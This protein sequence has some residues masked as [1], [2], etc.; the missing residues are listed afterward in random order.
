MNCLLCVFWVV[1]PLTMATEGVESDPAAAEARAAQLEQAIRNFWSHRKSIRGDIITTARL[2]DSDIV[3]VGGGG[4]E[5]LKVDDLVLRR[6][7]QIVRDV[8]KTGEQEFKDVPEQRQVEFEDGKDYWVY[9][10]GSDA[11]GKRV[12]AGKRD[13]RRI[14]AELRSAFDLRNVSERRT[15]FGRTYDLEWAPQKPGAGCDGGLITSF[16]SDGILVH[17][18]CRNAAGESIRTLLVRNLQYDIPFDRSRF[19]FTPPE[20]VAVKELKEGE[21]LPITAKKTETPPTEE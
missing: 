12:G 7:E 20:G 10:Q 18:V 1:A 2:G 15:E 8:V 9:L 11:A 16:Q 4:Y 17:E 14:I 13:P 6:K 5:E 19:T 3:R 21:H